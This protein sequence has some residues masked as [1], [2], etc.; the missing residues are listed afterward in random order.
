MK[1]HEIT[2]CCLVLITIAP[3]ACGGGSGQAPAVAIPTPTAHTPVSDIQGPGNTSP[4]DGQTV[5]LSAIVT[6]DFQDNDSDTQNNLGGFFVQQATSD[7][8]H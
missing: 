8:D 1:N 6:G 2:L 3:A 7:S 4:L 5:T